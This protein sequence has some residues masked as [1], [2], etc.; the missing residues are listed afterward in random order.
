MT[1]TRHS[2]LPA[3]ARALRHA[4]TCRTTRRALP[5]GTALYVRARPPH[6]R[7]LVPAGNLVLRWTGAGVSFLEDGPWRAWEPA[8]YRAM[9][10]AGATTDERGRVI[11]SEFRG[12]PLAELLADGSL[13]D[14]WKRRATVAAAREL[15]RAHRL[16]VRWPSGATRAFSHG[17]ATARN[18]IVDPA[19]DAARWI[20]FETLHDGESSEVDR[21]AD[22]L[23]ALLVSAA[24]SWAADEPLVDALVSGYDDDHRIR[25]LA[26]LLTQADTL[27]HLAQGAVPR[28]RRVRLATQI[29]T[30][31]AR[32]GFR[33]PS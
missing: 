32:A 14:A 31:R 25:R 6:A 33:P 27:Y 20:D 29:R 4:K 13:D 1:P 17:D 22:D 12:S 18:V 23:R 8:V 2:L 16:H 5:D 10:V 7:W 19:A 21:H 9:G 3:V 11:V 15:G 24:E 30:F 28:A 26:E